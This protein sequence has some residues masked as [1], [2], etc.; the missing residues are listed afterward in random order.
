MKFKLNTQEFSSYFEIGAVKQG[1]LDITAKMY[2]LTYKEV[3]AAAC[4][5]T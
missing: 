1:L 4:T 2:G 5:R 3:P